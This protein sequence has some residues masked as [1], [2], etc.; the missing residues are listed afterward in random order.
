M[1]LHI[2]TDIKNKIEGFET[3][4]VNNG[5]VDGLTSI[6]NSSCIFLF[7]DN[8][9]DQ[10]DYEQAVQTLFLSIKKVRLGGE[11]IIKGICFDRICS[12]YKSNE[13]DIEEINNKLSVLKSFQ[14]YNNIITAIESSG[15]Q[16]NTVSHTGLFYEIKS[17]RIS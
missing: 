16:I 3:L 10:I 13:L 1:K 4:C 9:M 14:N 15:F 8:A 12:L 6:I 11:L 5:A 17:K 7:L 2:T